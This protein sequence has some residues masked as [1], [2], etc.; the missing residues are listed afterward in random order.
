MAPVGPIFVVTGVPGSGKTSVARSLATR[1][2]LGMHVPVDDL[3]EWVVAGIAHPVPTWTAE[4]GRQFGLARRAAAGVARIYAEAGFAVALDDVLSPAGAAAAF[5]TPLAGLA[6]HKV[7]LLPRLEVAL[8]RNAAR[9]TKGFDT[10]DLAETIRHLHGSFDAAA[11][12]AA[13]WTVLDNGAETVDA[14]L[15]RTTI[16]TRD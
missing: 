11:F 15:A 1:F 8:A 2:P 7:A 9:T 3:R 5:D 16:D 13:G 14:V 6:V 10:A 4:T 12:R